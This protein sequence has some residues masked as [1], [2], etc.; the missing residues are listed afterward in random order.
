MRLLVA[1]D[2]WS[3]RKRNFV[4][5]ACKPGFLWPITDTF[6]HRCLMIQ[7]NVCGFVSGKYVGLSTAFGHAKAR[8][9]G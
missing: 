2:L 8:R 3:Q 1:R 7:A 9:D 4:D 5:S 6:C